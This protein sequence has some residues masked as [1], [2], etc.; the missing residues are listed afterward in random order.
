MVSAMTVPQRAPDRNCWN[1]RCCIGVP[2]YGVCQISIALRVRM[3]F[4]LTRLARDCLWQSSLGDLSPNLCWGRGRAVAD[5]IRSRD[6]AA[7]P[8]SPPIS[9]GGEVAERSLSKTDD[10]A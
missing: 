1:G 6:S 3:Y 5:R 7:S 9:V 2:A 10:T 8:T 4:P